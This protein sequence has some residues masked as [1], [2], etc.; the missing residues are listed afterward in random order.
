LGVKK[1]NVALVGCGYWGKHFLRLCMQHPQI[2]FSGILDSSGSRINEL[3]Q[4]YPDVHFYNNLESIANDTEVSAVIV[5]TGLSSHFAIC[6]RLLQAGKHVLCEKP[7]TFTAKES[8]TLGQIA[9]TNGL[10]LLVGHTFEYNSAVLHAKHEID[11]G[12]LGELKYLSFRRC[13]NGPIRDD[14]D[15]VYDLATHDV[16]IAN[17]LLGSVPD[18]VNATGYKLLGANQYDLANIDLIYPSGLSVNICVSWMELVKQREL[19]VIG[20]MG[21]LLFNDVVPSEKIRLYHTIAPTTQTRGDFGDFQ[22]SVSNNEVTI[23]NINYKEPLREELEHF[24]ACIN[25]Q[26]QPRTG[27]QNAANVVR[28]L[29]AI[30]ESIACQGQSVKVAK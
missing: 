1:I 11:R 23:P 19:K 17:L 6:Q 14:A 18:A 26:Q 7:L 24:L 9:D 8:E 13:G 5:A 22:L 21:M 27:W 29:E 15:V 30:E 2:R 10:T 12:A 20:S 3:Q 28:V 16:S 25:G 4:L